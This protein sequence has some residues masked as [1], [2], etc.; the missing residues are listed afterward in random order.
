MTMQLRVAMLVF[1]VVFLLIVVKSVSHGRLQLKYA[2]MW[3]LL[4]LLI[5]IAAVFPD[6]VNALAHL[7]GFQL[8]SNMVLLLG[9]IAA[10]ALCLS[11]TIIV[12]WQS[13]DI[14]TLVSRV[15]LLEKQLYEH[16]KDVREKNVEDI[17][18]ASEEQSDDQA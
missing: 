4:A 16:Q 14:R 12:S 15:S 13:R 9:L 2:L 3:L 8:S 17:S 18:T 5:I 11:L 7:L 1:A 10:L 6:I